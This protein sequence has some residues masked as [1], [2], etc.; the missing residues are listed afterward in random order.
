MKYEKPV[1]I[2]I[3]LKLSET[4]L[5]G[6]KLIGGGSGPGNLSGCQYWSGRLKPCSTTAS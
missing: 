6:C 4:A 1:L 5:G 3:S 2:K